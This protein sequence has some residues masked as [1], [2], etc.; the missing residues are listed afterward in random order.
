M[1]T[2][3]FALAMLEIAQ[4][5]IAVDCSSCRYQLKAASRAT[6]NGSVRMYLRLDAAAIVVHLILAPPPQA[7]VVDHHLS[8]GVRIS[9]SLGEDRS[10]VFTEVVCSFYA[11]F[12]YEGSC[13]LRRRLM[14]RGQHIGVKGLRFY[15]NIQSLVVL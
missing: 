8:A 1:Y 5:C 13:S 14:F 6:K 4:G 9:K 15:F 11:V 10:R 7:R 3:L 2:G 12:A